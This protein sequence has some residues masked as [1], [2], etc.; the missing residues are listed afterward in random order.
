MLVM[1]NTFIVYSLLNMEFIVKPPSF[2]VSKY[3]DFIYEY[4]KKHQKDTIYTLL[5]LD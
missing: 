1:K 3:V 2:G 5:I 4:G